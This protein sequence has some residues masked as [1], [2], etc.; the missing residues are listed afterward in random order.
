VAEAV[1]PTVG[2]FG[3]GGLVSFVLGSIML[4]NTGVPGYAVNLGVIGGIA[5]CAAG[6]LVLV[7]WLVFRSRRSLQVTGDDAMRS[8]IAELLEPVGENN[9]TWVLV[10]GERWRARC[11]TALPGG[12]RVRVVGREG[13]LLQV[14]PL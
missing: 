7:V 5:V 1:T 14:E 8:D 13:L 2:V 4:M 12:A 3:V 10:R 11:A 6:L 9:E